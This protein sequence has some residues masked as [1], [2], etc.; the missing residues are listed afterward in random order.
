[1][2]T[3]SPVDQDIA[4]IIEE[5][6]QKNKLSPKSK[7]YYDMSGNTGEGNLSRS[8]SVSITDEGKDSINLFIKTA[9]HIS[10]DSLLSFKSLYA[11]E[12]YFYD[13]IYPVFSKFLNEKGA[14]AYKNVPRCFATSPKN[15]I[16]LEN[17]AKK[18]YVVLEDG[19]FM[20][21][22]EI[23]LA[24]ETIARFH[25]ISFAFKDQRYD[26]FVKLMQPVNDIGICLNNKEFTLQKKSYTSSFLSNLDPV[27][28]KN[29]IQKVEDLIQSPNYGAY[30]TLL[31]SS[32]YS[33]L[34]QGD[35]WNNN[36]MFLYGVSIGTVHCN[37]F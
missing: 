36:V 26:E 8:F 9:L 32:E 20:N 23:E 19:E 25:A 12:I 7:I 35:L 24:L 16:A 17:L 1:M 5:I 27:I 2:A 3:T 10:G 37:K 34:I 6:I 28:D 30:D 21:D 11:N 18:G 13:V 15:I 4:S 33:I 31:A 29:V 14:V 22:N